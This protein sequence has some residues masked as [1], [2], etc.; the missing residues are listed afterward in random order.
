MTW[1]AK[2]NPTPL[3]AG[4]LDKPHRSITIASGASLASGAIV[5]NSA[6]SAIPPVLPRAPL[7]GGVTAS[8]KYIPSIK[9]AT[10][11]SQNPTAI[12]AADT[13]AS[14]ADVVSDAYFMGE[15]TGEIM[16]YDA[17]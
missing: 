14:S 8:D 10:D 5:A 2:F 13:D 12:L 9:T 7:L 3:N 15:F 6:T 17:S 11:G 4:D 1:S 16:S